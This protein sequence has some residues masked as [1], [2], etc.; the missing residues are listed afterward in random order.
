MPASSRQQAVHLCCKPLEGGCC[1]FRIFWIPGRH[2]RA[3]MCNTSNIRALTMVDIPAAAT[4]SANTL[5]AW[6][7]SPC[8]H[9]QHLHLATSQGD[10]W[11]NFSTGHTACNRNA[12]HQQE[13]AGVLDASAFS[14]TITP[15]G[16]GG[17]GTSA[18]DVKDPWLACDCSSH[19]AVLTAAS[20]LKSLQRMHL[21][22]PAGDL[23]AFTYSTK[24]TLR[25]GGVQSLQRM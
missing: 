15:G 14:T 12:L 7:P 2:H 10:L 25:F 1:C 21:R 22:E 9:V 17:G 5:D 3:C 16:G 11:V 8:L 6:S 20:S 24:I 13:A 18:M 19:N 4:Q 23:S